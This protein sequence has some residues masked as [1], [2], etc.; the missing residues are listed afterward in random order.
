MAKKISRISK[1]QYLK[2]VQCPKR[3]WFYRHRPDL[4]P[5]ISDEQQQ[6]FDIGH[7]VGEYA[8]KYFGKGRLI[9]EKYYE[10]E[11]SINSTKRAVADRIDIIF[12][13][14]ASS[15]DGAYSRIDIFKKASKSDQWDLIEVKAST[16]VKDYHIDDISFQ[17][18]AFIKA[19]YN[20][21]KSILM[22]INN[23]YIRYGEL[24]LSELF[25]LEDCTDIIEDRIA[26]IPDVLKDLLAVVNNKKEPEIDRGQQCSSPFDCEYMDHCWQDFPEYS[27]YNIFRGG[28]LESLLDD[29]ITEIKDVPENFDMT[30]LQHINVSSHKNGKI[31]VDKERITGFIETLKYPLYYLDYE[32]IFPA[33]PLYDN[34]S[35][36]QQIPFQFSLHIQKEMGGDLDHVEFLH[37]EAGDPRPGF[38]KALIENCGSFGSVVVYNQGFESRINNE[39]GIS[40]PEYRVKLAKINE[41]M[42]DLLIPFRS[43]YLYHPQMYGSASLKSVLPAFITDLSYDDLVIQDGGSASSLYLSCVKGVLSDKEKRQVYQNL[44]K[45][46]GT[47]TLAEVRLLEILHNTVK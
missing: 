10:I 2:G 31:Y 46:C 18:Y 15:Q 29:N 24:N 32:T 45:Y 27:V 35:P 20:I 11:K 26:R 5:E 40:F 22:H 36:Y 14:T 41:R 4:A 25:T 38:I 16:T 47:D 23:S 43:K 39:L 42:V 12:E 37:T 8:Q 44:K 3:L 13:A 33:I 1:S 7:E 34:S 30:K 17:R 6:I 19:G 28:K 21:R 9:D